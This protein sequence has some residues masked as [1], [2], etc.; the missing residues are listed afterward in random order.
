MMHGRI[1]LVVALD[2]A[3]FP[4]HAKLLR[5]LIV[6]Q[7]VFVEPHALPRRPG[8]TWAAE[9][10][11][12]E[13]KIVL[14]CTGSELGTMLP[15]LVGEERGSLEASRERDS[16]VAGRRATTSEPAILRRGSDP[17]VKGHSMPKRRQV[18]PPR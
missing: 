17:R 14:F 18:W 5:D 7:S 8:I 13:T 1:G 11:V 15:E 12:G 9:E 16:M 6:S 10:R 2:H 4:K 3:I